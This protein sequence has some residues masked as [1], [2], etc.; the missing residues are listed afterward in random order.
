MRPVYMQILLDINDWIM[1]TILNYDQD[2]MM[3]NDWHSQDNKNNSI[4]HTHKHAHKHTL[5]TLTHFVRQ[6]LVRFRLIFVGHY[7]VHCSRITFIFEKFTFS[8]FHYS[9]SF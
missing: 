1:K 6:S 4:Y 7:S 3:I 8:K 5:N 9:L 2:K